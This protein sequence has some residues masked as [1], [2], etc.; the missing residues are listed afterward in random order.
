VIGE[1]QGEDHFASFERGDEDISRRL[2][3]EDEDWKYVEITARDHFNPARRRGLLLRLA[4]YLGV[5]A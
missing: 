5:E 2:L 3:V 1:Y 4:R